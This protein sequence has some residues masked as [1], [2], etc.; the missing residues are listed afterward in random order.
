MS[1]PVAVVPA[2]DTRTVVPA[3]DPCSV[4]PAP[5]SAL[6]DRTAAWLQVVAHPVRVHVL[7]ALAREGALTAGELQE[8]VGI[9]ASALSHHLRLMRDARLVQSEPR[10]RHRVY[11]LDDP[12]VAHI[13]N[14]ALKHVAESD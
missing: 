11:R 10:G 14:D 1:D 4:V 8:R 12:H 5:D 7:W 6:L 9:E 2:P 3:P 13:V